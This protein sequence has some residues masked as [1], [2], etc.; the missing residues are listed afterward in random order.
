LVGVLALVLAV[1]AVLMLLSDRSESRVGS[2]L[3]SP[4][5]AAAS[6]FRRFRSSRR[7]CT[8]A[9]TNIAAS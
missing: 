2:R 5:C 1:L 8:V 4:R 6:A 9:I 3:R 7:I